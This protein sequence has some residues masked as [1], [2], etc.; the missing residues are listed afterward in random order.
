MEIRRLNRRYYKK[1]HKL[2][3]NLDKE[4]EFL[5]FEEGERKITEEEVHKMLSSSLED[6]VFI[7]AFDGE[8]L[9]GYLSSFRG[10]Y[11]RIRHVSY[12]VVG[13]RKKYRSKGIGRK[14]FEELFIW[15]YENN[16]KRLELTVVCNN[17]I[18][19]N[20]Y[21]KVGFKVEGLKK[22]AIFKD[23]LYYDE[24]YMSKLL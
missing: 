1:L 6:L 21:K 12:S 24:Y 7:G 8:E 10:K 22:R 18:A 11:N 23:G 20:L 16:I 4:S 15:A 3:Y 14:L 9:I 19:I 13:I 2:F 17:I 5:L